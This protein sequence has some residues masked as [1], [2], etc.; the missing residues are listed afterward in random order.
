MNYNVLLVLF[1]EPEG[2]EPPNVKLVG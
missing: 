2:L 1:C